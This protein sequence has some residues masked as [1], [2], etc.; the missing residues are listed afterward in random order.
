MD[1]IDEGITK[2]LISV[3]AMTRV[4]VIRDITSSQYMLIVR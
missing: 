2:K 1:D 3:N 4:G